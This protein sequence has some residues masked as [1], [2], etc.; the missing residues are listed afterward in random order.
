MKYVPVA[1]KSLG[2]KIRD[3][4]FMHFQIN[5]FSKFVISTDHICSKYSMK[6]LASQ[7]PIVL[8]RSGLGCTLI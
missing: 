3:S 5:E 8:T 6:V 7:N 4:F 2:K 1:L